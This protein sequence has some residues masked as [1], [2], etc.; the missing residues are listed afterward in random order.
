MAEATKD[1]P[2]QNN[3]QGTPPAGGPLRGST[4]DHRARGGSASQRLEDDSLARRE[5]RLVG[6]ALL[7]DSR[8]TIPSLS[9]RRPPGK[10]V[11]LLAEWPQSEKAPIK[12]CLCDLP[13]DYSLRR[14]VRL[15]KCRWKIEQD[16]HQLKEELGLDHYEGR[17]WQG[18]HHHVTMVMV[19]HAFLTLE[20]LRGKKNFW[21]DPAQNAT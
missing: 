13:A 2:A 9:G 4:A 3:G 12:Y 8:A 20:T 5:S 11:W 17:N 16:Y 21:V 6:V 7:G 1:R 15:V 14:I 19:A 18:W 10:Q